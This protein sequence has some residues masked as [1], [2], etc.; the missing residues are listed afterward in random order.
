VIFWAI[1]K[2]LKI[3]L[4]SLHIHFKW[5]TICTKTI[6]KENG[7]DGIMKIEKLSDRQIRCILDKSDLA[8]RHIKISELAYG[9]EKVKKLFQ[10]MMRQASY[11]LGFDAEDIPLMIEAIPVSS[12]CIVFMITKVED[13]DELDTRFSKFTPEDEDFDDYPMDDS[14]GFDMDDGYGDY[15][16]EHNTTAE[17][18]AGA[19]EV[20]N[21]FNKI[22]DYMKKNVLPVDDN[23]S[24]SFVPFNESLVPDKDSNLKVPSYNKA[25]GG[26]DASIKLTR[27][28]SF[29]S[30][31]EVMDVSRLIAG[32]YQDSNTLYKDSEDGIY[33]LLLNKGG[34]DLE[35]F[36]KI[37]NMLN[38]FGHKTHF[39]YA[40]ED[41]M[42]EHFDVIISESAIQ[43]LSLM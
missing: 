13:P 6:I 29:D 37:S 34:C 32:M 4:I 10:E 31:D 7:S 23:E 8:D 18:P 11:E 26:D 21:I 17:E 28:Y 20:I 2:L 1:W 38:E 30:L 35:D 22:K 40:S 39:N 24:S 25:A 16:Y 19:D 43:K 41:Y 36:N 33:Y 15:S 5:Y 12:E 14:P 27:I 9:S 3:D 42:N